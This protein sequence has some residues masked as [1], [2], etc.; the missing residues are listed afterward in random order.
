MRDSACVQYWPNPAHKKETTEAGPP[1]WH[2]GKDACP[3]RMSVDERNELLR[4]S[5]PLDP[6]NPCSRRWAIR[7]AEGLLEFFD[8]KWTGTLEGDDVFHGH[9]ASYVP[10]AI[11]R[12][13]RD[14]GD[15]SGA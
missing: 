9:P 8:V 15:V 1:G 11:L 7:R 13:F 2:P 12:R 5:I 3:E 6:D 4:D 14:R 10:V